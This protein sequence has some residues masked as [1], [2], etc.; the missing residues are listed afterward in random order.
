[1]GPA[2]ALQGGAVPSAAEVVARLEEVRTR[3]RYHG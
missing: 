2:P 3:V 1:L